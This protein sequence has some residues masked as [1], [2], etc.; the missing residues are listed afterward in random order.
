MADP[1]S[2]KI[3]RNRWLVISLLR[4]AGVAVVVIGLLVVSG[5]IPLPPAAGYVLLAIGLLDTFLVPQ[6]LARKWRSPRP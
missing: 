1:V 2:E 4:M 3:A 6:L 5:T